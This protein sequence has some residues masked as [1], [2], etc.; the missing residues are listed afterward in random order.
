MGSLH[1]SRIHKWFA[2]SPPV[3]WTVRQLRELLIGSLKQGPVPQH[4]AFVMDGNRRFARNHH[5]ETVEGHNLGFESLARILEVCYK[6]GVKV[7][8]IYAFSIENFKRSK[9]EVDALM[10]MAKVKLQQLA[11]HGAL[12]DR[13]G[14]SVRV[15][16][17]RELISPDVL[18]AVD[19]AGRIEC[20]LPIYLAARDHN[21]SHEDGGNIQHAHPQPHHPSKR[22][23]SESHITQHIRKQMLEEDTEGGA[24]LPESRSASPSS[25]EPTGADDGRSSS[26]STVINPS[27]KDDVQNGPTFLDP[28][29][30]SA[31]TLNDN[32]MTADA[33]PLDLLVRTSGVER[34]SDFMLWQA[35]ENTSI[36]FLKCLWPE[37]DLWQLLPV[38]VEWQWQQKKLQEEQQRVRGRS[39]VE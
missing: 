7:V 3:A 34:L 15:L 30:I 24:E 13:Y 22:T 27:E 29:S 38:L 21:G 9:H 39:K 18:M 12:L 25:K 37:F 5:I 6:T 32:M 33:P 17:Q 1:D 31:Q 10:S 8:T 23:F 2:T 26:T 36:V 20:L 14:A 19:K 28:E 35:H 11:E 16:G 4:V